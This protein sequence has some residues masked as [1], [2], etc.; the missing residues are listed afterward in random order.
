MERVEIFDANDHHLPQ[1]IQTIVNISLKSCNLINL[2]YENEINFFGNWLGKNRLKNDLTF[3]IPKHHPD[4]P[5]EIGWDLINMNKFLSLPKILHKSNTNNCLK[6]SDLT[7]RKSLLLPASPM[8]EFEQAYDDLWE[9][10][11]EHFDEEVRDPN[12]CF[13]DAEGYKEFADSWKLI[14][15][16]SCLQELEQDGLIFKGVIDKR[17]THIMKFRFLK[18]ENLISFLDDISEQLKLIV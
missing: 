13:P 15:Y 4:V 6:R 3:S 16:S 5:G 8:E 12:F 14:D 7:Q 11:L 2:T 10:L 1:V 9:Y 17:F 18:K